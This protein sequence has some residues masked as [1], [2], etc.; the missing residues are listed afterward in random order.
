MFRFSLIFLL[1]LIP[2][3]SFAQQAQSLKELVNAENNFASISRDKSTR[4]AFVACLADSAIVFGRGAA[5][6]GKPMWEGRPAGP[7][8]LFWW[9]TVSDVSSSGDFGYNTGPFEFSRN[10]TEKPAGFGYFSS[11]WKK[12]ADGV[13]KVVIDIGIGIPSEEEKKSEWRTN[14]IKVKKSKDKGTAVKKGLMTFD[15]T[16]N[17]KLTQLHTSFIKEYLSTEGRLHRMGY[18]PLTTASEILNFKDGLEQYQFQPIGGDIASS[19]DMG[20]TYGNVKAI[21]KEDSKE[22]NLN[23]MRVYKKEDGKNWKVV[24]DVIGG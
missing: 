22:V 2:I 13:W 20:Y 3:S 21:N 5:V 16:Y 11:V 15:K 8:L 7:G 14:S 10:R 18:F 9:P 1:F 12:G 17:E 23:Y 4:D 19:G 6:L 24:L